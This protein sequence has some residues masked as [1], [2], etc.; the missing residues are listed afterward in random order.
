[1]NRKIK[2]LFVT[3]VYENIDTG[4]GKFAQI[5]PLLNQGNIIDLYIL[6]PDI[7]IESNFFLG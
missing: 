2:V 4:P 1:M 3:S 7:K 6:T 5:L